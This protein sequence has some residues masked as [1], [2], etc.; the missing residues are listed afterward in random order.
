LVSG[1][2]EV[3]LCSLEVAQQVL[4]AQ[5]PGLHACCSGA[6]EKMHDRAAT[7]IGA[8]NST[9]VIASETMILL[10]INLRTSTN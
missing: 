9:A 6:L 4:L 8:A 1:C 10:N 2:D 5:E 7:P 3:D